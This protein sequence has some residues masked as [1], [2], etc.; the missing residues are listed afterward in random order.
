MASIQ[1]NRVGG[2]TYWRI[3]E[4]RRVNG[5]PRPVP[6]MHLGTADALLD[7][8]LHAP[9]GRLR[10]RSFRHGD[11][12]ALLAAALR[13]DVVALIDRHVP[14]KRRAL[15]VG[16][17]LVLAAVNRAVRP[18]SKRG[19]AKWAATT[20]LERFVPR[21]KVKDL[22]SQYFWDQMDTVSLETLRAIEEDLTRRVVSELDVDL[23]TLFYDTTNYFTYIAT[24]NKRSKLTKRGHSKQKRA[25][26]RLF[27][28]A[29]LV[30]RTK[31]L[32]LLSHVYEGKLTAYRAESSLARLIEPFFARHDDEARKF[33]KSIFQATADILPDERNH[34][35]TIRFHGLASP[36][37][38]R[39]L[40]NLCALVS[41]R[42][43]R[44]PGTDLRLRFEAPAS[45]K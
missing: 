1:K 2:R 21:L 32:P 13:L 31:G 36:R 28:L 7:R 43:V 37:A 8:L 14:K 3:V 39:A 11:V 10:L 35:L 34:L 12:A 4:S 41:E 15:S 9:A 24:T 6:I 44:Y 16:Q 18:R 26:L 17:T 19:F 38:T 23:D 27:G 5:K 30:D 42:K 22:S 40:A 29:L 33:L 25:D 20:S 45:Q